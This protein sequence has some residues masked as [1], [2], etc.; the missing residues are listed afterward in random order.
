MVEYA[1]SLDSIFHSLADPIRRDIVYRVSRREL[2]VSEIAKNYEVSLAAISKHLKVL[3]RARLIIKR[4]K[5]K[6]Q[7]VQVAPLALK[8]AAEYLEAYRLIWEERHEA[9][10]R[11]LKKMK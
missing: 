5:G 1:V 7:M 8:E 9:L 2:S 11:L 10:D 6:Q 3:E 4:R